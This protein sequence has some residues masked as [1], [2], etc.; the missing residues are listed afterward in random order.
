M[1]NI[2]FLFTFLIF[3]WS[4]SQKNVGVNTANPIGPLHIDAARDNQGIPTTI[5][6]QNDV[7]F[8]ENSRLGI[9][10]S[11][12]ETKLHINS[13]TFRS[14]FRLADGTQG[15]GKLLQSLNSQGD[16]KWEQ[17][18]S[19]I[20]VPNDGNGY[21]GVING[22]M[23]YISR[24]ITLKPGKWLIRSNL[25]LY[26]KYPASINQ[27]FYARF[28]WAELNGTTYSLTNDAMYGN[29]FGGL[30]ALIYGIASGSTLINNQSGSDKTYYLVTRTPV[31]FGGY[32]PNNKW[33]SL[34]AGWW[35]ETSIIA[36]PAN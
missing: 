1:K 27:G 4:Y 18:I 15:D 16:V 12:P 30:Y 7:L 28:S 22:D 11:T 13:A 17:R 5:T 25:L 9:G 24:K 23:Q 31:F 2:L 34:G 6:S 36:F 29:V 14:G 19:S 35:G 26:T 10:T 21:Y 8:S 3:N 33:D 20:N 32:D